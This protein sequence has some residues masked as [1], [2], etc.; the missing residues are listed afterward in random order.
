MDAFLFSRYPRHF[1]SFSL[2]LEMTSFG[3]RLIP[4]A[5]SFLFQPIERP[6]L[7]QCTL[8][9]VAWEIQSIS[10]SLTKALLYHPA[11]LHFLRAFLIHPRTIVYAC[12]ALLYGYEISIPSNQTVFV[13]RF[14]ILSPLTDPLCWWVVMHWSE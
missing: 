6:V 3:G 1:I 4:S 5:F 14:T 2:E 13:P 12:H 11:P 9:Q 7:F 10:L 8:L